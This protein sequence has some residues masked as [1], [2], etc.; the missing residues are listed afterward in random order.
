MRDKGWAANSQVTSDFPH[1]PR[2]AASTNVRSEKIFLSR[3]PEWQDG[4]AEGRLSTV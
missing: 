3:D 4:G 1:F 2:V